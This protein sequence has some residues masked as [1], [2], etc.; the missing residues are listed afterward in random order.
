MKFWQYSL[1]SGQINLGISIVAPN[2]WM[3]ILFLCVSILWI[4]IAA[5][6]IWKE[7]KK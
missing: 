2:L 4:V 5:Y 3:S 7:W 6:D 1:L